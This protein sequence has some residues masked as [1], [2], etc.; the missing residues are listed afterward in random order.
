MTATKYQV[1]EF[2]TDITRIYERGNAT[3]HSYRPAIQKLLENIHNITATNEPKAVRCGAPDFSISTTNTNLPIGHLEAKDIGV[4]IEKFKGANKEQFDRYKAALPNLI[5]TNCCEWDFYRYGKKINSIRIADYVM[6]IQPNKTKFVELE[7]TLRHFLQRAPLDITSSDD[8]AERMAGMASLTKDVLTK[9]LK[10]DRKSNTGLMQQYKSLKDMLMHD[11]SVEDFADI[12]AETIAYGM[13][14]ARLHDPTPDTFDRHEA[15]DLLPK[16]NPFL[17]NL[18]SYIAGP[19]LDERIKTIIDDLADIF[20]VCNVKELLSGFREKRGDPFIHFYEDFLG[21]YNPKKRQ[22]RGV[23]YTPEPV[24]K[25][26]VRSVDEV[27]QSEFNLPL[28]LAD[29][30]KVVVDWETGQ[31]LSKKGKRDT[32]KKE[33]HRVQILDPAAGTGTFLAE[34]INQIAAKVNQ[35]ASGSWQSYVAKN[36]LPR[37]HGFELL[38]APYAMCHMKLDLALSELGFETEKANDRLGVYLTNSLEE[39]IPLNRDLPFASWLSDE[40]EGANEIKRDLPIMCVIGNPPYS[41][42]S[43]NKGDWIEGLMKDYKVSADLKRP[44]QAKWLSDDYV[45]FIRFSEYMIEKNGEGVLGF[46]TNHSYLDN[47]TFMDMRSHL[48]STFDKI[49]VLDLHGNAK[50][51]EISPDGQADKNVFAIQQGVAVII[52]VKKKE[53]SDKPAQIFH[54]ELWGE[55]QSKYRALEKKNLRSGWNKLTPQKPQY[56]FVPRDYELE[57]KYL[58]WPSIPEIFSPNGRPAPGM[59]TTHDEFA[60]SLTPKEAIQKVEK[61][62]TTKT[63]DEARQLFKLCSQE[64][65]N[66]QSAKQE[67]SNSDW[68]SELE[69]I[70][71]RPFD[72]RYTIFSPHVAVHRRLRAMRHMLAGDN[73]ALVTGRQGQVVGSMAWNLVFCTDIPSDLNLYYRGGGQTLPLYL[74]DETDNS[75]RVNFD[76]KIYAKIQKAATDKTNKAPDEMAVFDYIYGVLHSPDYRAT[77]KDFLKSDF[78]RIPYPQS[79]AKFWQFAKAGGTLRSLH[80]MDEKIIGETPYSFVDGTIGKKGADEITKPRFETG[81]V[82]INDDKYFADV[83][84][85]A[86]EFYIGGYQPAQKWLKDRKGQTLSF[87]DARHYQKIIKILSET[88][89]IMQSMPQINDKS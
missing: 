82:W 63:E 65:W 77:Y 20:R 35:T 45:K 23:Y 80:L 34:T 79:P 21:K 83:P 75:K 29:N 43:Q 54:N 66:Y 73:V 39:G 62:L 12:Y 58:S 40:A 76:K 78:P 50:K 28:G 46:I 87:D 86:W 14:A 57:K 69:A 74:Y 68:R 9:A 26:I 24:V 52:A 59:V 88:D 25:F 61:L 70:A 71:Y 51:K 36:L 11:L 38:M 8:L 15:L 64:Q 48:L 27:L 3:E 30:S 13:F 85:A 1:D 42:H 5:Y 32:I 31:T 37:L 2:I 55:R 60:I 49:Y 72:T 33:V 44:A 7:E 47:P 4:G 22:S 10:K 84:K 53:S 17:R 81:K 67:L 6:G 19:D 16:T 41:G 56:F 89:K 18:F